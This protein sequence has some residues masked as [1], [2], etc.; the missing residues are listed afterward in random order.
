MA[1]VLE[2]V[3][4]WPAVLGFVAGEVDAHA[5]SAP[6]CKGDKLMAVI[7][8]ADGCEDL[9]PAPAVLLAARAHEDTIDPADV[10]VA[11][12]FGNCQPLVF[13]EF[14]PTPK[15]TRESHILSNILSWNYELPMQ[16]RCCQFHS[17]I[18]AMLDHC[19]ELSCRPCK[20]TPKREGAMQCRQCGII[21]EDL[22]GTSNFL[23]CIACY[24]SRE[25]GRGV[26]GDS[27]ASAGAVT[28]GSS[29]VGI[30]GLAGAEH[31]EATGRVLS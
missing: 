6:S 13:P 9:A 21:H 15:S 7:G 8:K 20:P 27:A 16:P 2:D 14:S 11:S 1:N 3:L 26:E 5:K 29:S 23:M 22:T 4:Q 18:Q 10:A 12:V 24:A 31:S 28:A 19:A 25:D 17:G 30:G